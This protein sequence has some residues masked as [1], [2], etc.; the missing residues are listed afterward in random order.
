MDDSL[1]VRNAHRRSIL[2]LDRSLPGICQ[3]DHTSVVPVLPAEGL[4][5]ERPEVLRIVIERHQRRGADEIIK[6]ERGR[7]RAIVLRVHR[8]RLVGLLV[9]DVGIID[10]APRFVQNTHEVPYEGVLFVGILPVVLFGVHPELLIN[11]TGLDESLVGLSLFHIV[12]RKERI[13][14]HF[15]DIFPLIG[16]DVV[17]Q[18]H[19]SRRKTD[20]FRVQIVDLLFGGKEPAIA[21]VGLARIMVEQAE[22]EFVKNRGFFAVVALVR[23]HVGDGRGKVVPGDARVDVS[24]KLGGG[25]ACG[26]EK[27]KRHGNEP[28]RFRGLHE[29]GHGGRVKIR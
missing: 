17:V 18:K 28:R 10:L 15:F 19:G 14:Q 26:E 29:M 20:A 2:L 12:Q 23:A 24:V 1:F 5:P 4:S 22:V 6:K 7:P 3:D 13:D 8:I 11:L 25:T 9:R 16:K 21:R 27:R